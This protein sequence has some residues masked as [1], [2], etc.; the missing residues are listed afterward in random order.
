MQVIDVERATAPPVAAAVA[1]TPEAQQLEVRLANFLDGAPLELQVLAKQKLKGVPVITP[2]PHQG[3]HGTAATQ[4]QGPGSYHSGGASQA[5]TV[6]D[7]EALSEVAEPA[8]VVP[9]GAPVSLK[10]SYAA[11]TENNAESMED[12]EPSPPSMR[13]RTEQTATDTTYTECSECL[14]VPCSC[15]SHRAAAPTNL[16]E[17]IAQFAHFAAIPAPAG[18]V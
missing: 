18:G 4:R 15:S 8:K 7:L 17:Q 1:L 11:L 12:R 10:N 2:Q 9:K 3:G 13:R 14:T 5:A 6:V 16:Q